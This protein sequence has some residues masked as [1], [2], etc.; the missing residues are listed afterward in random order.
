[1]SDPSSHEDLA[2]EQEREAADLEQ[3][4]QELQ[5]DIESAKDE[6]RTLEQSETIATPERASEPE[7]GPPPETQYTNKRDEDDER[8]DEGV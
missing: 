8:A 2:R 5:A 7:D 4:S 3:R 1:M 6:L